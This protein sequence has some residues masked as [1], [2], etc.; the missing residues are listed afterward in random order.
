VTLLNVFVPLLTG[1]FLAL[2]GGFLGVLTTRWLVETLD[3]VDGPPGAVLL[4]LL[5]LS[6]ALVLGALGF[7]F[8]LR[9]LRK[10]SRNNREA[11]RREEDR[12]RGLELAKGLGV[13]G[14]KALLKFCVDKRKEVPARGVACLALGFLGYKPAV[15]ILI[16]LAND[17][18]LGVV[19]DATRALEMIPSRRAVQPMISLAREATRIEVRNRAIDVL[20]A[21]GR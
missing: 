16:K 10:Q 19:N 9:W 18:D 1:I 17:S 4:V 12:A 7:T 6:F 13:A 5:V 3:I 8:C 15:P 11:I 21:L 14:E 20:G 2:I